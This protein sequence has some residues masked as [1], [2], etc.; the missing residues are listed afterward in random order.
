MW[1]ALARESWS[2]PETA[3]DYVEEALF[4]AKGACLQGKVM[5]DKK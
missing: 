2:R 5:E 1:K 3:E 4:I